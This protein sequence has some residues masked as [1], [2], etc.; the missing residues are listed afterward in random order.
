[1]TSSE[2]FGHALKDI[3]ARHVLDAISLQLTESELEEE[4][5]EENAARRANSDNESSS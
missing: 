3:D 5:Q 2:D 1:M 4:E